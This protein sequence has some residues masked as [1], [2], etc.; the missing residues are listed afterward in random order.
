MVGD[1]ERESKLTQIKQWRDLGES[2]FDEMYE[3]HS[4]RDASACFLDARENFRDAIKLAEELGL[5]ADAEYLRQRLEHIEEV[6]LS[7]FAG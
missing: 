5:A 1:T 3:V 2:A 6:Y 7:Q 4:W